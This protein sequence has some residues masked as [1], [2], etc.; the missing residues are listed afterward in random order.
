MQYADIQQATVPATV[1][2]KSGARITLL[3][4]LKREMGVWKISDL[5]VTEDQKESGVGKKVGVRE[6]GEKGPSGAA[7]YDANENDRLV[8]HLAWLK[9]GIRGLSGDGTAGQESAQE[10]IKASTS[11]AAKAWHLA[12]SAGSNAY[13]LIL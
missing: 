3:L 4:N 8:C 7:K 13:P 10:H 1:S 12:T 5:A 6:D 9:V 2:P 11:T